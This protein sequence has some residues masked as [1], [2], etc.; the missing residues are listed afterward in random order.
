MVKCPI[1]GREYDSAEFCPECGIKLEQP[2]E[3]QSAQEGQGYTHT[4]DDKGK[5]LSTWDFVL[6]ELVARVPILNLVLFCVWSF[7]SE[8]NL[9]RR[10]WA[11]SRLIWVAIGLALSVLAVAGVIIMG[12][13]V[14]VTVSDFINWVLYE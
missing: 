1:C 12:L 10:N 4:Q 2:R 6:M 5:L 11:R 13:F 3:S 8:A 14:G 9:T 7:S